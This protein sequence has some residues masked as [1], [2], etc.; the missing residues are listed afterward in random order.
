M[1][2]PAVKRFVTATAISRSTL[3]FEDSLRWCGR[4]PEGA[5]ARLT[6]GRLR[7]RIRLI[8]AGYP[9]GQSRM[10][11][12]RRELPLSKGA[13]HPDPKT[14]RRIVSAR[15]LQ[16]GPS[17]AVADEMTIAPVQSLLRT[18][19]LS[20][21]GRRLPVAPGGQRVAHRGPMPIGPGGLD[22]DAPGVRVA[23]FGQG[24]PALGLARGILTRDQPQVGHQFPWAVEALEVHD[25]GEQD[26][27]RQGV[28]PAEA[29]QPADGLPIGCG[30]GQRLDL[31]VEL[32]LARQGLLQREQA[33]LERALQGRPVE[34]LLPDPAPV[35]LAPVVAGEIEA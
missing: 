31:F 8:C 18:P 24:A 17:R 15:T 1:E 33:G 27:G 26:H 9:G 7:R 14:R 13:R 16:S 22:E 28:D 4:F 35:R 2:G 19:R 30:L 34:A 12:L 6:S 29:P 23:G 11:P 25:L 10:T 20:D 5:G 32:R 21:D 3:M